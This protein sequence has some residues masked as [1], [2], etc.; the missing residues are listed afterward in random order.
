MLV[1]CD[2]LLWSSMSLYFLYSKSTKSF[3]DFEIEIIEINA[4]MKM[5]SIIIPRI[6]KSIKAISILLV[7]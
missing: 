2:C 4:A 5:A 1:F 3:M 7:E 6:A